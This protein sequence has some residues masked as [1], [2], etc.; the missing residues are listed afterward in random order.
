[1]ESPPRG[2]VVNQAALL[3]RVSRGF[4][5]DL[6]TINHLRRRLVLLRHRLDA[7][8]RIASGPG[9]IFLRIVDFVLVVLLIGLRQDELIVQIV[10]SG[11]V[12]LSL[13]RGQPLNQ[14]PV[15]GQR[16]LGLFQACLDLF[17]LRAERG[18]VLF[19]LALRRGISHIHVAICSLQG[20][21]G[22]RLLIFA[23]GHL[24]QFQS[25]ENGGLVD[26]GRSRSVAGAGGVE[27]LGRLHQ[28][29][30]GRSQKQHERERED[31]LHRSHIES[32]GL[33]ILMRGRA[34][35][36]ED[37]EASLSRPT[38]RDGLQVRTAAALFSLGFAN[39]GQAS[40]AFR[41]SSGKRMHRGRGD[42]IRDA[43]HDCGSAGATDESAKEKL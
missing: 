21:F 23:P 24:R 1:M 12:G 38:V 19:Q 14:F 28:S 42:G 40:Q 10:F 36:N 31:F 33:P 6:Q 41:W 3:G 15:R 4:Q 37:E 8:A 30:D 16:I 43:K 32:P 26:G 29:V 11:S 5:T 39:G 2:E 27:R 7:A 35:Y 34:G 22:E 9:Q 20:L 13:F 18:R 25:G 17:S